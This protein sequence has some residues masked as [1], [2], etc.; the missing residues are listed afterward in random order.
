[1][2]IEEKIHFIRKSSTP[3]LDK[4][5]N[6]VKKLKNELTNSANSNAGS[7]K[8][9]TVPAKP[10]PV[11]V[12]APT[13]PISSIQNIFGPLANVILVTIFTIFML[14]GRED[15]R[16]RFPVRIE[17]SKTPQGSTYAVR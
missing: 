2:T 15:L 1:M 6:S 9:F 13:S 14:L 17:V 5:S 11:Q 12:V 8:P 4:D 16:D 10:L 7:K 3:P